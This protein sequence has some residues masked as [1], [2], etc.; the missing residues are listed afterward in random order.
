MS[1]RSIFALIFGWGGKTGINCF[2]LITGYFMC[3]ST[4]SLRKFLKLLLEIEFYKIVFLLIFCL[5]GYTSF[6]FMSAWK[7]ILPIYGLGTGFTSSY[8][9]FFLFIPY[10]NL[11]IHAMNKRQHQVLIGLC[12]GV[13]TVLQT[14]LK[15]PAA[16][17]YVGWFVV[18]Y[19]I[20]AY[21]RIYPNELLDSGKVWRNATC[22]CLFVSW[23]SVIFG[24]LIYQK[25][26]KRVY[27]YFVSDSNKLLAIMTAVSAFL[28]FKNMRMKHHLVINKIAASA[29]GVLL[30]H[31]NSD[32]MRQWL[33]RDVLQNTRAFHS[34]F[35]VIHA[36]G[37][38]LAVYCICTVIDMVRIVALEKPFFEWYDR[39]KS[40]WKRIL[41]NQG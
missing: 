20:A 3:R 8:L 21:I 24:A 1:A 9:C 12:L 13:G 30:I 19:L 28:F 36:F 29:F 40:E 25:Y 14:F 22:V 10:I 7:A 26:N 4:I 6:T 39:R 16:F 38:V 34:S 23:C 15:A 5:S 41:G 11:L 17:T 2:V 33:W 35:F 31:A 27:Y 18:C 32:T 37:S